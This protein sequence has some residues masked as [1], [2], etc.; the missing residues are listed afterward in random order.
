MPET[1]ILRRRYRS[2]SPDGATVMREASSREDL[3]RLIH[4]F[5][6][7]VAVREGDETWEVDCATS[8]GAGGA[9]RLHQMA[10]NRRILVHIA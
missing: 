7:A 5:G 6:H 4:D 8:R 1:V 3:A 2:H 9:N 10:C